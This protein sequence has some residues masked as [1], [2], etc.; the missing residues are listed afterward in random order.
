LS[1]NVT[2]ST[3]SS[4]AVNRPIITTR[5]DS[6]FYEHDTAATV[7][8]WPIN[9]NSW[10]HLLACT[11]SNKANY[12]SMQIAASFF[13]NTDLY[14]RSTNGSGTTAWTKIWNS[15]N[16][17]AGSG[18]DADLL[19]GINSTSFARVD[20]TSTFTVATNFQSNLGA[21]S[22]SLSNPPLQAYATGGNS[23]FMSFHR[24]GS[25]AVNFGLDS[26]NILRIGGWSASANRWVL[27]MSGNM[28]AAG[29]INSNSDIKLKTNIKTLTNSLNKVIQMRGV[30]FDR[31]D[32]EGKHQ[33][34]FIAQEIEEIYPELVSENQGTKSV[35]YGNITAILV[36][37]IK[38][39][40]EQINNLIKQIEN[41]KK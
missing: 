6:G 28:T 13:N 20:S 5:T 22:G 19:D 38:E 3:F 39:Q 25:F 23:A 18:L 37:A 34:G 4:D 31:I 17:G 12:Y 21:T 10:M 40:Q 1:G 16:D 35:A 41:L 15:D 11:H 8:G 29:D 14:Y 32:I 36:E 27:D 9:S 30:E 24:A 7:D 26:D 33:I 2:G